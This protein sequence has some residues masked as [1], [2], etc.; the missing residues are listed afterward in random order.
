MS[1]RTTEDG[2]GIIG[3]NNIAFDNSAFYIDRGE[4]EYTV[5]R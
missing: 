5:S 2:L 3:E 1:R 4:L